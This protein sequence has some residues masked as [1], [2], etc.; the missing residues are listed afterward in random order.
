[1]LVLGN[2]WGFTNGTNWT[3][4][5]SGWCRYGLNFGYWGSGF[6]EAGMVCESWWDWWIGNLRLEFPRSKY[7]YSFVFFR[8]GFMS[9]V[10]HSSLLL[11]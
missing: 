10:L 6:E 9:G 8:F 7:Q 3:N 4:S 11:C 2:G 5:H 1:M